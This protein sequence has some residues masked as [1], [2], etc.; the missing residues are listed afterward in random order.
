VG[1]DPECLLAQK[2][3]EQGHNAG[4]TQPSNT[5]QG[6]YA[7]APSGFLLASIN[8]NDP[9]A[10]A[11]M[12]RRALDKWNAMTPFERKSS[13]D[14]TAQTKEVR[15]PEALYPEDGL[16]LRVFSRDLPRENLPK[17]WRGSAWNQ[18]YAWFR[19]SE[20][21]SMLPMTLTRGQVQRVPDTLIRR[22]VRFN[23]V[24]NVRGQTPPLMDKDIVRAELNA[25]IVGASGGSVDV[26]FRG[27][28][29][30]EAAGKWAVAGYRDMNSP[31]EQRLYIDLE[32]YG[33]AK[34]STTTEQFTSFEMAALGTRYGATQYN[35]RT[36]DIGPAPIGYALVKAAKTSAERVA[37]A[38]YYAY[39]WR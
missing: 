1:K 24:D 25:E 26:V 22:L 18:D 15:R 2:V 33:R 17:D 16:A 7:A 5:R 21:R 39:G 9:V 31:S 37:P 10:M 6:I 23:F 27:R 34:F 14:V 19:R 29:R 11:G 3:F 4:R 8:T 12:L 28:S 36:D 32:L 20:V 35:G 38:H 30:T 13:E